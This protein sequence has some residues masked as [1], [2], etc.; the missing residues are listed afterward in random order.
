MRILYFHQYFNLPSSSGGTRAYEMAKKLIARGHEVTV[1]CAHNGKGDLPL[2]KNANDNIRKGTI[3]GINIIQFNLNYSNHLSLPRRAIIF[4]QYAFKSIF[5]AIRLDY[6]LVLASSTP[7]TAGLPGIFSKWIRNK[8]FVF[9]VRDLWPEL[10]KA[11]GI[12]KNPLLLAG[13]SLLEWLT[14][15]SASSCIALAPGIKEGIA[16]RSPPD[17]YIYTIPNGCDLD[18]FRPMLRENLELAEVNSAD[19][20]AVFTGAHGIANGLDALLDTAQILLERARTDIVLVFIG[21]GSCK[22]RLI[23]RANQEGLHNCKFFDPM[24]KN[25]LNRIVSSCDIGLMILDDV[26][27]FYYGT[28][29]NKFFDYISSGLPVVNNY[30]GWLAD[31]INEYNCGIATSAGDPRALADALCQLADDQQLRST[32]GRNSRSLAEKQFS[33]EKLATDF[34]DCLERTFANAG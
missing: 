5:I 27:A 15:K 25:Q 21:D 16:K 12:V 31:L 1:V 24:P 33:R 18:L 26:P 13:L 22:S 10:P 19:C 8:P 14:Y 11:M 6:D 32:Y 7:L 4:F 30:P 23:K 28:S 34:V 3:E 29:P 20:V 9:E 17:R 2:P